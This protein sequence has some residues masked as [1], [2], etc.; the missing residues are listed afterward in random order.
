MAIARSLADRRLDWFIIFLLCII[1]L[2]AAYPLWFVLI[3]SVSHPVSISTGKVIIAPHG[4]NLG[5]YEQLFRTRRIW[6][7]YRNS[8]FYTFFGTLIN[9]FVTVSAGYALSRRTLP[10]RKWLSLYFIITMYVS[11][12]MMP[13]YLNLRSLRMLNTVWALLI[14]GAVNVFNMIIARSYFENAIPESLYESAHIDGASLLRYY[15][16]FAIPLSK[17]MIAVLT[18]FFA[19]GH[20]NSYFNAMIYI[21][22][23][24]IQTLQVIIKQMTTTS[25]SMLQETMTAE[26]IA[27]EVMEKQLLKYGIVVVSTIPMILMYPFVQRYLIQGIMIGAIKG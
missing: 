4:F 15:A 16:Q 18:L 6:I 11:G 1:T 22:N 14:P 19:L 10:G 12:G 20:W 7:G 24:N 3:A 21:T 2:L 9:L 25:S 13:S 8:L 26:D 17:P 27:K 23:D 5:A